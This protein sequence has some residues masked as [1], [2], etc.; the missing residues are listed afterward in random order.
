MIEFVYA[1]LGTRPLQKTQMKQTVLSIVLIVMGIKIS[2]FGVLAAAYSGSVIPVALVVVGVGMAVF[3]FL[4]LRSKPI[5][6]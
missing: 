2:G 3:G 4:R 6:N 5:S 1:N